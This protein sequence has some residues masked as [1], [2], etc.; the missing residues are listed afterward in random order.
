MVDARLHSRYNRHYMTPQQIA[1]LS[2]FTPADIEHVAT[3]AQGYNYLRNQLGIGGIYGRAV[4]PASERLARA[5]HDGLSDG[6]YL[7]DDQGEGFTGAERM[8][9][10]AALEL[11]TRV[12][13][14]V[15]A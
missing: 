12:A 15:A 10:L 2:Q 8:A 3:L 1:A 14:A 13:P 4:N 11:A 5:I 9:Y 7:A 6:W